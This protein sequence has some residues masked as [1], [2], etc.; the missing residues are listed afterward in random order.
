MVVPAGVLSMSIVAPIVA[1]RDRM[2]ASPWWP[3]PAWTPAGSKP[4]PL[5]VMRRRSSPVGR[6]VDGDDRPSRAGVPGDVAQGLVRQAE[7]VGDRVGVGLVGGGEIELE[8]DHRVV[9]ELLR[10]RDEAG[11][12]APCRPAAPAAA[13]R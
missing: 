9:A 5:S 6:G 4:R 2:F 10:D 13:R 3:K 1:A 12:A 8:V 11:R 7:E